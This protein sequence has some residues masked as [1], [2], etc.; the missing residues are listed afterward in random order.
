MSEIKLILFK[1]G[2]IGVETPFSEKER[3][4]ALSQRTW[5][6]AE[7]CWICPGAIIEEV[8]DAFPDGTQSPAFRRRLAEIKDMSGKA[9]HIASDFD[10][11]DFGHGK[12]MMP[13]QRAGLEFI[14]VTGGNTL[15]ADQ[16]GCISGDA[17]IS[18]HRAGKSFKIRLDQLYLKFNHLG[19]NWKP[20]AEIPTMARSLIPNETFRLNKVLK[21]VYKGEKD[22]VL[23]KT[24]SGKELKL[25]PDHRVRT[26]VGWV[27]A[28][29]L[30][31]GSQI[32]INGKHVCKLCGLDK[33]VI[34]YKYAKFRGFCKECMYRQ[35]RDNGLSHKRQHKHDGS[36]YIEGGLLYHPYN[37]TGGIPEHRLIMEAKE[38]GLSLD[39]WL[40]KLRTNDLGGCTFL[41]LDMEVH[42]V[43]G[44]A[45]DNRIE[46]LQQVTCSEHHTI[47]ERYKNISDVFIPKEDTII[48]IEPA[49][50]Q[51]VFDIVMDEPA[52][53]FIANGIVVHN[54]G[55]TVETLAYLQLHPEM[56]PVVIVCPASL[57]LNWEREARSWLETED[58]IEVISGGKVHELDSDIVVINYDILKKWTQALQSINPQILILD[59][60]HA[61]K[62]QKRSKKMPDGTTRR[63][64]VGRSKAAKDLASI[65]PHKILLTGTPILNRPSEL[66]NQ[67]QII[68][69]AQY[70][71]KR[72]FQWH[73]RYANAYKSR[74]GWDF[75]GALNL[76]ELAQSLKSIMI[77][78]TKKQVLAELPDKRRQTIL[79]PIDN[80]REYDTA[81]SDFLT[82]IAE[83]KGADAA[84]RVSHVE[85]LAKIEVLRQIAVRGK[86]KQAIDWIKNFLSTGEK[87]V[88]FATH[89]ETIN[90]LMTAFGEGTVKIDGGV[91]S[92][93]RQAAVDAF[94]ND[95]ETRLFVGNIKAAGVGITLTAASD[96]VFLEL[97][98][99]PALMEQAED[100]LHR[101][102]QKNAVNCYYLLA[103]KTVDASI[104]AMLERKRVVI[105]QITEDENTLSFELF[106][107]VRGE[108]S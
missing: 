13:F 68:D 44:N 50:I 75:S 49:G 10:L 20:E 47:H 74:F 57:K 72:F 12:K 30:K 101:I 105:D 100:R 23:I 70:T 90:A 53:N 91:S 82:W 19:G 69:P 16:M 95:P 18:V 31:V 76:E 84:D 43:N 46:N 73:K 3:C 104:A 103:E 48:S 27:E 22:T 86:T 6:R 61:V 5:G 106:E 88:V 24:Q 60:S 79:I 14:E 71:D 67:L 107:M 108:Q 63:V 35:L 51:R 28:W 39:E 40:E 77:R 97:D 33:D 59:E 66:W 42:H 78:R 7:R 9:T 92:E 54:C 25:T 65:T 87:L 85:E 45:F 41:S 102:S 80:R 8:T 2:N 99:T 58:R 4:K 83:Q 94:Q 29:T 15:I 36:R 81:E 52:H 55:K 93:K 62:S 37:T 56:R 96:V 38:N 64:D 32:L 26:P 21:V 17:M 1:S 11:P 34:T 98:W 89:R